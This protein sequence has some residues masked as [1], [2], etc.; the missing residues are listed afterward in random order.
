MRSTL[1]WS[2]MSTSHAVP[3]ISAAMRWAPGATMSATTTLAPA[4]AR[5]RQYS[6]PMPPP[7]PVTIATVPSS[8]I[9]GRPS[10]A[11]GERDL[12][13]A[14]GGHV[15]GVTARDADA[16]LLELGRAEQATLEAL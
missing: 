16:A 8:C 4:A 11:R 7:P 1:A 5:P 2:A 9:D 12:P 13:V 6:A 14:A 10:V 3:P 15:P